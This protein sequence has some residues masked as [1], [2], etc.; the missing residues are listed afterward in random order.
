MTKKN[1]QQAEKLIAAFHYQSSKILDRLCDIAASAET[2]IELANV[3]SLLQSIGN[4]SAV[5]DR[6]DIFNKKN[7]TGLKFYPGVED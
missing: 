2:E 5:R 1:K 6:I 3:G 7:R 4:R